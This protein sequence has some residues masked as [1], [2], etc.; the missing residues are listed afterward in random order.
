[1]TS[2]KYNNFT[3]GYHTTKLSTLYETIKRV[4]EW[5]TVTAMQIYLSNGRG[6]DF[7]Y[8]TTDDILSAK[9]VIDSSGMWLCAHSKLVHNPAGAKEIT[10][11]RY[12]D[13]LESTRVGI[14]SEL[15][16]ISAIGGRGVVVHTGC[17]DDYNLGIKTIAETVI[18][19]LTRITPFTKMCAKACNLKVGDFISKRKV[20][21]ENSAGEGSKLGST[22]EDFKK[23]LEMVPLAYISQVGICIDTAHAFGAGMCDWGIPEEVEKFY[24]TFRRTIGIERLSLFHLNDSRKSIKKGLDAPFGSKKDRHANL[25]MGYTFENERQEGLKKFFEMAYTHNIP[26]IGE[27]PS[28]TDDTG[29]SGPG[30]IRDFV[31]VKCLLDDTKFPL[32]AYSET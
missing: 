18:D 21:L 28:S 29:D 12:K 16:I 14:T 1:M 22:L 2:V 27:P 30:G 31:Y 5:E 17:S 23:I 10:N 3:Y 6:Y 26:I 11:P 32:F 13:M 25:G 4:V 24:D 15:D 7:T 20:I 19:V 9:S 8:P